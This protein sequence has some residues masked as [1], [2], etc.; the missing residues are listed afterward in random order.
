MLQRVEMA[1]LLV[2]NR[3]CCM[4]I[5]MVLSSHERLGNTERRTGLWFE[6]FALPYYAFRDAGA[7]IMLTSPKGGYAPVDPDSDGPHAHAPTLARFQQDVQARAA[8]ND[9]LQLQQ[10]HAED[11]DGAFYPGGHGSLW[12]LSS[13]KRSG[14]LIAALYDMKKP[15]AFICHGV[16][17]LLSVTDSHGQHLIRGKRLTGFSNSEV[18]AMGLKDIV[19]LKLED[20]L[21]KR[22]A[23][24]SKGADDTSHVVRD[25]HL[26]TGQNH[27]ST[28]ALTQTLLETLQT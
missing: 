6:E 23:I 9:T 14:E 2:S 15:I 25:G 19:P 27:P 21:Q 1:I 24:Y 7:D 22:G 12:D 8:L 4:R 20:E 13:N 5:L 18:A 26:I 17:A 28:A 3:L 16:S 10:I 11:F